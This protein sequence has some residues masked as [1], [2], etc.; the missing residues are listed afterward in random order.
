MLQAKRVFPQG[1]GI[2]SSVSPEPA[3]RSGV[4]AHPTA[5][6]AKK[7]R[8]S[9]LDMGPPSAVTGCLGATEH[10]GTSTMPRRRWR[11][12]YLEGDSMD[13]ITTLPLWIRLLRI[14]AILF[15]AFLLFG[16]W[17]ERRMVF[18][19]SVAW[20]KPLPDEAEEIE[21]A[22]ADGTELSGVWFPAEE[23]SAVLLHCHGNAGNIS[24]RFH[25]ARH[26]QDLGWS[27][28]LF[29]Y[30]G[31]GRSHGKPTEEGM[32]ADARAAIAMARRLS[33]NDVVAYGRSLG[34]VPAV[35][36]ACEGETVGLI[37][38]SPFLDAQ[39]MAREILPIPGLG[40]LLR[41]GLDNSSRIGSITCPLLVLHGEEDEMVPL[42]QALE[43][44]RLAPEPKRLVVIPGGRHNDSRQS[45]VAL[46]A[47]RE[48]LA[49][50]P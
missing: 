16:W 1:S 11:C 45:G 43:V 18:I 2:G 10:T 28:F 15:C 44:H 8:R 27:V 9:M 26:W 20:D 50:L 29:D 6:A 21:F 5:A 32:I 23:A 36:L 19:P 49:E 38:D 4:A 35:V 42:E 39:A 25:V 12:K 14:L 46:D 7:A 3:A 22:S 48:F 40:K 34:T 37:L 33:G 24:H 41:I 31:Y 30:R 13:E 47:V 17:L